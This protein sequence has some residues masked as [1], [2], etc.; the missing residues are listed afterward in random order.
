MSKTGPK[1]KYTPELVARAW[2]YLD[3]YTFQG[4]VIPSHEELAEVLSVHRDTL[5]EWAKHDDKVMSDILAK[6]NSIQARMVINN[7]LIGDYN[8]T[9]AKLLL[10]KHGYSDKTE[11]NSNVVIKDKT[12]ADMYGKPEP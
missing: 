5:Y 11:S 1:T 7:S 9:I 4:S 8:A 10:G 12:F 3:D 2:E 6:C